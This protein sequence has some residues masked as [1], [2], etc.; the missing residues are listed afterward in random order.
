MLYFRNF[1]A[2]F[3][4]NYQTEI[5]QQCLVTEQVISLSGCLHTSRLRICYGGDMLISDNS[6]FFSNFFG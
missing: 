3:E 5:V 6:L 4:K 2:F 1:L